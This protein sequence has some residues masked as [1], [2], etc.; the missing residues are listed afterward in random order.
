MTETRSKAIEGI[1]L[2]TA[3]EPLG[4]YS[5]L[6]EVN[7][8]VFLSGMMPLQAGKVIFTGQLDREKGREAAYLAALNAL[9]VLKKHYG[10]L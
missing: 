4:Q 3:P 7:G 5:A 9:A 6:S 2:P 10:D 1:V 8:L